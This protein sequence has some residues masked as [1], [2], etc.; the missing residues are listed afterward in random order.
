MDTGNHELHPVSETEHVGTQQCEAWV[1]R[2][3]LLEEVSL[4]LTQKNWEGLDGCMAGCGGKSVPGIASEQRTEAGWSQTYA[5]CHEGTVHPG[6]SSFLAGPLQE[7]EVGTQHPLGL[8]L[9]EAGGWTAGWLASW[10]AWGR[11]QLRGDDD[12]G[13]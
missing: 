5:G 11:A 8:F 4:K 2:E 3:G 1:V 12:P 10:A 9:A 13:C 7:G 6:P